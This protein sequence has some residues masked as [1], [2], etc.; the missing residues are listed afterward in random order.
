MRLY[1]FTNHVFGLQNIERRRLKIARINE[2]NDPF[3][4]LGVASRSPGIRQRYRKLKDD[5]NRYMGMLCFSGWRNPVQWSHYSEHH[6][7]ICLGFDFAAEVHKVRYTRHRLQPNVRALQNEGQ[8]AQKHMKEILTT[9]F[10]HWS[11]EQEYRVFPNL[12]ERDDN[13]LYFFEFETGLT[14]RQVI[15]GHRSTVSRKDVYD[16]L[17]DLAKSVNCF[18][19]RLAFQ[20]FEVVRQKDA[21]LWN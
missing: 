10:L 3:E 17:G 5:L 20:T 2:L 11:Y 7:G 6:R 4:F 21:S 1:H 13:G 18:K 19:A 12:T 16:A 15:V 8:A 9:K 14:L